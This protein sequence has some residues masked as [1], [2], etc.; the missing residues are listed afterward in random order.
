M[1]GWIDRQIGR[2]INEWYGYLVDGQNLQMNQWRDNKIDG[3]I[4]Q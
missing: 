2:E 3:W 1:D 4:D